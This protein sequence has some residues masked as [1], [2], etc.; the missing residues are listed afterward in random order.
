[1]N[2]MVTEFGTQARQLAPKIVIGLLV[3]WGF[4]AG[5]RRL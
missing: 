5:Q 2:E 1:M 3:L 4:L